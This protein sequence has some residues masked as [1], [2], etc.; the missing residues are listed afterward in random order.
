MEVSQQPPVAT[1]EEADRHLRKEMGFVPIL[2]MSIGAIIG[3]G[4]LLASLAASATA[5]PAAIISW[6]IGGIFIIFVGMSYAELSGMLPRTGAIVRYPVLSHGGFTGWVIGWT[7]W[8]SAITVPAIEA[9]AVVTYIGSS[10]VA[11]H[12]GLTTQDHGITVLQAP[13]G[14]LFFLGLMALFFV[15][16][17]FGIKWLARI[18]HVVTWWKLIVPTVT[19]IFLFTLFRASNFTDYHGGFNPMGTGYIFQALSTTGIIFAYLGFRQALDYAGESKRPQRD[20]P[21]ATIL[22]VVICMLIYVG[23]QIAF[24]GALRWGSA[25]TAAG[26]WAGLT[27]GKWANAPLYSALATAGVG[28]LGTYAWFLLV[29]AGISPSG[30]G[31]IYMGTSTRTNYGMS[32]AGFAPK[33]LQR[34]NRFGIPWVSLIVALVIGCVFVVPYGSWYKLVGFITSTTAL[35]YIM[36]GLGLPVF[37]KF[38]PQLHRPFRL[39]TAWFWAPVG[40]LAAMMI[41]YWAGFSTLI[42]VYAA[43]FIGLC[44]F[45]WYYAPMRGWVSRPLGG[46]LGLVF[47]GLWVWESVEGGWVMRVAPTKSGAVNPSNAWTFGEYDIALSA[48]V[49]GFCV[50]LWLIGNAQCKKHVASTAWLIFMLLAVLPDSYYGQFGP[51]ANGKAPLVFPWGTLI[52][53]GIGLITYYWGVASGFNT[54]ELQ[55]IVAST[56]PEPAVASGPSVGR[57][58][59][60]HNGR[61]PAHHMPL[62]RWGR[63]LHPT[64]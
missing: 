54:E 37:R 4:W 55:Q 62:P 22:S 28:W 14:I 9:E 17:Y 41:V 48:T 45:T 25:G 57:H 59:E 18:N 40:F 33:A 42:S 64:G 23:L 6:V 31:W 10:Q 2:F 29:D 43:V 58:E 15:L 32:V 27:S 30:T 20:V 53:V 1:F 7:Y 50:V 11:P 21:L 51:Y 36:G 52:A 3:S 63:H 8:L 26:D 35:T 13:W 38:A 44:L 5:G 24:V 56:A 46:A 47:L 19:F 12:A 39:R 61:H 60:R 49:I 34:P 16:N